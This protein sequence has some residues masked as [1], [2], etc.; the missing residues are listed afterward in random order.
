MPVVFNQDDVPAAPAGR[1]ASVQPLLDT[2]TTGSDNVRLVR[3]TLENDGAMAIEVR[4]PDL[5]W[6]QILTGTTSLAG[7]A[8]AAVLSD[9]HLALLPPGF[10]GRIESAAGAVVLYAEVPE[11]ARFDAAFAERPPRFRAIDWTR[12]PV[13]DAE[14]D[15]R[16]RIYM[17]T[18]KMFGTRAI[19]G[20]MIIYPPGTEAA[21][22]HHE[23]AEH[24]Q[25]VL[26]GRGTVFCNEVAHALR[27]GDVVYN[28]PHERHYFRC[29]GDEDFVFVEFFV[30]GIFKTVWADD[31]PVCTWLPSG[32]NI[33]GGAPVREIAAHSSA[34]FDSPHDV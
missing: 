15:A 21:N 2:A 8:G 32:R 27:A 33:E 4:R 6:L 31:A 10:S 18:P 28:Y 30:P 12:E 5:A 23:G 24:F 25:F 11:A 20:E 13:L 9:V 7:P 3:W 16:K 22:H 29:E 1:N 19:A 34:D 14:H 17:V 26:S